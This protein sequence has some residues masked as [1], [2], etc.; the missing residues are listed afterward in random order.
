MWQVL[1][2]SAR[3]QCVSHCVTTYACVF[4]EQIFDSA[5][6]TKALEDIKKQKKVRVRVMSALVYTLARM[7]LAHVM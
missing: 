1:A 5:R 3:H 2:H 4:H 6:Y 7:F